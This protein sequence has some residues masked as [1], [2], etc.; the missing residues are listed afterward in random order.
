MY[1]K[2]LIILEACKL[3]AS[4]SKESAR[5]IINNQYKFNYKDIQ[6]R[7]HTD[8]QK[9]ETFLRD[10]F[11][12]RYNGSKL[13]IP[14]ILKVLSVYFPDEFPYQSHWRMQETHVAYWELVPTI[15][16]VVPIAIGGEDNKENWVTTSMLHNAIKSNWTLEQ[17]GW[18]I[19]N[20][21]NLTEWDG[22]TSLFINIVDK[23]KELLKDQYIKKWYNL[24][25]KILFI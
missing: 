20:P 11:I 7:T 3:I 12:D 8:S 22:L 17:I 21:V 15:D 1:D 10:G 19:Q 24:T 13:V 5:N 4:G 2:A 25:K 16:H 9:M 6:K 18:E 23:D 14:G